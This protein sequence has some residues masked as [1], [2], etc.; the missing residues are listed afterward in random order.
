VEL[1]R[2]IIEDVANSP[3]LDAQ[4]CGT[5][6]ASPTPRGRHRAIHDCVTVITNLHCRYATRKNCSRCLSV[7]MS[8]GFVQHGRTSMRMTLT[9]LGIAALALS[10]SAH[11][12]KAETA[13]PW[14]AEY[15]DGEGQRNCGFAT[16]EQCRAA[17]SGN[18][19][20]C[21]ENPA[22]RAQAAARETTGSSHSSRT[23]R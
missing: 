3:F 16:A 23:R 6:S 14:C 5:G 20:Y 22:Y 12:T 15:S 8:G 18:G 17:I 21:L 10:L 4:T 7:F 13:Y 2:G 11:T 1:M 19:G 9:T